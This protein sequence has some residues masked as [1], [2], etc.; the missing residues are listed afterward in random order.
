M[1]ETDAIVLFDDITLGTPEPP[2]G[3]SGARTESAG[4]K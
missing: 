1:R 2:F 4:P 3:T